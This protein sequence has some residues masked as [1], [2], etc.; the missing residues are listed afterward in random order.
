MSPEKPLH[1]TLILERLDADL[2]ARR[3]TVKID[4]GAVDLKPRG[5]RGDRSAQLQLPVHVTFAVSATVAK[6][7]RGSMTVRVNDG[8]G[9]VVPRETARPSGQACDLAW[10]WSVQVTAVSQ[11]A[12]VSGDGKVTHQ[13]LTSADRDLLA[14]QPELSRGKAASLVATERQ[15]EMNKAGLARPDVSRGRVIIDH[16]PRCVGANRARDD[17]RGSGTP[18]R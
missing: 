11:R 16:P 18:K 7:D 12:P 10:A 1:R 13:H 4:P 17:Q 9:R 14:D 6:S 5:I 2:P 3:T 15:G 8:G